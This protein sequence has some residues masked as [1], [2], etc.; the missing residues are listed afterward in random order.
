MNN[1]VQSLTRPESVSAGCEG[2]QSAG[3]DASIVGGGWV[4]PPAVEYS[5]GGAG[6]GG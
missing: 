4:V 2:C 1:G 6:E 3:G 5:E